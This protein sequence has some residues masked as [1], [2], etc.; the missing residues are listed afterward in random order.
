MKSE[1]RKYGTT[2]FY[3]TLAA[4][5][6]LT[7]CVSCAAGLETLNPVYTYPATIAIC[8]LPFERSDAQSSLVDDIRAKIASFLTEKDDFNY[9]FYIP[10]S[11]DSE[12]IYHDG[13]TADN[14]TGFTTKVPRDSYWEE[15]NIQY[16]LFGAYR[17]SDNRIQLEVYLYS[18]NLMRSLLR[19]RFTLLPDKIQRLHEDI[20]SEI[21][22]VLKSYHTDRKPPLVK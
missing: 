14:T 5:M 4:I 7:I 17:E 8:F 6:V 11:A 15:T 2:L 1:L 20:A 9:Q 19:K 13:F 12:V 18:T 21:R 3:L 10:T 16:I 22:A